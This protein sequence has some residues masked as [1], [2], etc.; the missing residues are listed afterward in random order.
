MPKS[1]SMTSAGYVT[2]ITKKENPSGSG[3]ELK[4]KSAFEAFCKHTRFCIK[5]RVDPDQVTVPP[6]PQCSATSIMKKVKQSDDNDAK[7]AADIL[8]LEGI[9]CTLKENAYGLGPQTGPEDLRLSPLLSNSIWS[10]MQAT[11]L[12]RIVLW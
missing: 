7:A 12:M 9:E 6:K 11:L 8:T 2:I 5:N 3:V 10:S 1:S 4:T